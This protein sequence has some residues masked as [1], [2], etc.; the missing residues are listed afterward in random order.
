MTVNLPSPSGLQGADAARV[1]PVGMLLRRTRDEKRLSVA[2]VAT[3]LRI[4][5][6]YL[7]AI[8]KGAYERLP[9]RA[10]AVGFVR[11]YAE[12]LGLDGAEAARRFKL[13]RRGFDAPQDLALPAPIADRSIPGGRILIVA[14]VLAVCGYGLWYYASTANRHRP[15]AVAEVP[16]EL[17]TEPAAPSEAKAAT[18][19]PVTLPPSVEIPN[20]QIAAKPLQAASQPPVAAAPA[21][22]PE[23]P[24][25]P[26]HVYGVA[27]G[28]SR[29]VLRATGDCWIQIK[30]GGPDATFGKLLTT[31]DLYRAPAQPGLTV[32]IGDSDKIVITVDGKKVTLPTAPSRV[33][34]IAL[35]PAQLLA[36]TVPA[37][38]APVLATTPAAMPVA[39]AKPN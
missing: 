38:P 37:K 28:P 10:Y 30:G 29:I 3:A 33:R 8:E 9:G 23:T 4:R 7:D 22:A 32:R 6:A 18:R 36:W 27:D 35:D 17:A 26:P 34:N 11:A 16:P 14:L 25:A 31:G 15:D 1:Q 24:P 2:D 20:K 12:Y 19:E 21:V 39:P 13:E 5:A